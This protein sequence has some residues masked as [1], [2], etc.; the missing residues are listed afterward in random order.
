VRQWGG[1]FGIFTIWLIQGGLIIPI[2]SSNT[3]LGY[4]LCALAGHNERI[5]PD[6]FS[7]K[8]E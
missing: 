8:K 4:C 2:A 6:Y 3:M 1:L 5:I 7:S